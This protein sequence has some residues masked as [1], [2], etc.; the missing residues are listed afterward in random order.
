MLGKSSS[1]KSRDVC[2][3]CWDWLRANRLVS[4][5][6][7]TAPLSCLIQRVCFGLQ[8][9]TDNLQEES[10]NNQ[11]AG[12]ESNSHK[13]MHDKRSREKAGDNWE[14]APR[15]GFVALV[16]RDCV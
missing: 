12:T 8:A 14:E 2:A 13:D 5:L 6:F 16:G 9:T 10:A 11:T 7:R 15:G 4:D 1:P 3:T